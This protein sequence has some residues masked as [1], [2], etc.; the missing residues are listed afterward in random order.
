MSEEL[1]QVVTFPDVAG[2]DDPFSIKTTATD[3][4]VIRPAVVTVLMNREMARRVGR[5]LRKRAK[6]QGLPEPM[7]LRPKLSGAETTSRMAAMLIDEY[8]KYSG[9][10]P[11]KTLQNFLDD[12]TAK[13]MEDAIRTGRPLDRDA[14]RRA[15]GELWARAEAKR[16]EK[17]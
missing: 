8:E 4:S 9:H 14:V 5:K 1:E 2:L 12:R 7:V 3:G 15:I 10:F 16:A 11:L 6:E 17:K 13:V